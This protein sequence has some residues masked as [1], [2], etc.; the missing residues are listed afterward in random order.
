MTNI[1]RHSDADTVWLS[2]TRQGDAVAL[3]VADNGRG[4]TDGRKAPAYA[5]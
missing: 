5:A 1:A 2:L 4:R 3:L